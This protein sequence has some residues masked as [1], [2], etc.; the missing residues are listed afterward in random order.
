[1]HEVIFAGKFETDVKLL[2][3]DAFNVER[4]SN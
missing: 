1:M 3:Y 2:E 4:E